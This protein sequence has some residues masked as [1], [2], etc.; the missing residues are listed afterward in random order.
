[1]LIAEDDATNRMVVVKMLQEFTTEA[2]I[3]TDG[4]Q[5][6][7]AASETDYD[8]VLMDVRM[9]GWPCGN[10]SDSRPWRP[11]RGTAHHCSDRKCIRRRYQAMP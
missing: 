10:Q 4:V 11:L 7:Q 1:V 5:A 6:V 9:P 2:R 8:L 3:A